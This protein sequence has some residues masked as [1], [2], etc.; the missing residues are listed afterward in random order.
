[1]ELNDLR[2]KK[3][4]AD[5]AKEMEEKE[6][7]FKIEEEKKKIQAATKRADSS[8]SKTTFLTSDRSA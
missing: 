4:E 7:A 8:K 3:E 1:M 2:R 6:L 5:K